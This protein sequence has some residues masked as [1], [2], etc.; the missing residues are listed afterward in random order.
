MLVAFAYSNVRADHIQVK[1][2]LTVLFC[3][4]FCTVLR[5]Q[6]IQALCLLESTVWKH[7]EK[8]DCPLSLEIKMLLNYTEWQY[9]DELW[10]LLWHYKT[11]QCKQRG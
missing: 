11:L 10:I 5:N 3:G 9:D 1:K 6:F 2:Q 4:L 8:S 7:S